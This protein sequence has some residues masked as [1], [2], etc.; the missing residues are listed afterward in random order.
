M[1]QWHLDHLGGA[2]RG[3]KKGHLE[4]ELCGKKLN[5]RWHLVKMH[6]KAGEKRENWLLIKGGDDDSLAPQT[7]VDQYRQDH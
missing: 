1:G 6:G 4:F 3:L 7:R 2:H 5:G